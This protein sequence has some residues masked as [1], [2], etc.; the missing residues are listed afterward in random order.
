MHSIIAAFD[1]A[2][3]APQGQAVW[4]PPGTYNITRHIV[5]EIGQSEQCIYRPKVVREPE[6]TRSYV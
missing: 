6:W 4:V 5:F 2:I 3:A 1:A